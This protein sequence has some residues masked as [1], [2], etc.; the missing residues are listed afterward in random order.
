[1]HQEEHSHGGM[2]FLASKHCLEH[3]WA[4][5]L[6][7]CITERCSQQDTAGTAAM[8]GGGPSREGGARW[9]SYVLSPVVNST[10]PAGATMTLPATV[11]WQPGQHTHLC[12]TGSS[13]TMRGF[14]A[15]G[16]GARSRS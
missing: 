15:V 6:M 14:S 7:R 2:L 10:L 1:M 11:V 12:W 9:G 13:Q 8:L 5:P 3:L 16:H 4:P